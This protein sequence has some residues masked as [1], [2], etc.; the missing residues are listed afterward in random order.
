MMVLLGYFLIAGVAA[1][2]A[3]A[4]IGLFLTNLIIGHFRNSDRIAQWIN[5]LASGMKKESHTNH[6]RRRFECFSRCQTQAR[7]ASVLI[8]HR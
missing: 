4:L 8:R 3:S 7:L 5:F 2:T 1:I 6:R